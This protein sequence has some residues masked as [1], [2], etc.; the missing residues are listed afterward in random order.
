MVVSSAQAGEIVRSGPERVSL[1]ELFTSEGCSSCPP[2]EDWMTGLRKHPELWKRFVPVAFHVDYWDYLGWKDGLAAASF[3]G[4]QSRYAASWGS[5]GVYTPG[6]VLNGKERRG[7]P[8]SALPK[9]D[10]GVLFVERQGDTY[11]ITFE[12]AGEAGPY[13]VHAALLGFDVVTDVK[14]G[15]N[16]GRRLVHD[17]TVMDFKEAV[18]APG[19]ERFESSVE[20]KASRAAGKLGIAVWLTREGSL[21]PLQAAGAYLS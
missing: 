6:F 9:G 10:V 16:S 11:R 20:L 12:P 15:E 7:Q 5:G 2:A 4:R 13:S 8:L 18:M 14:S 17:F 19:G 3:S 21:E 1:L